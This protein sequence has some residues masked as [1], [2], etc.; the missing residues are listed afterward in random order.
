MPSF[1]VTLTSA[2]TNYNMLT[3]IRAIDSTFIDV[4]AHVV[5]QS[6]PTTNAGHKIKVA[7]DSNLSATRFGYELSAGE[8]QILPG[9]GRYHLKGLYARSDNAG[10]KLN[11]DV[12]R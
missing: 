3:L 2:N 5:I 1:Q 10:S 7:T 9:D 6:D 4:G 12:T 8:G 11:I